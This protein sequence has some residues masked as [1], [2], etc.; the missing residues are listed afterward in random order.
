MV[1]PSIQSVR[2]RL[3]DEFDFSDDADEV[4]RSS[5]DVEGV[6]KLSKGNAERFA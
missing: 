6:R 5:S 3:L 1:H 2:K 4:P